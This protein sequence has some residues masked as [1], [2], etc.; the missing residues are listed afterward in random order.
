MRY[1]AAFGPATPADL[2]AW[3]GL[4]GLR[5]VLEGLRPRLRP[6]RD[7]R[8]RELLD[9]PDAPR[10]DPET[11]APPRF[12]PEY[13]NLLLSHADRSRFIVEGERRR[14]GAAPGPVKG[15][16]LHDGTGLGTWWIDRDAA[17]GA[18][19]LNVRR[20][21]RLTARA[22]G[23]VAAEGRRLLRLTDPG[24]GA[25]DVRFTAVD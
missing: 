22:E 20:L 2:V 10:P 8:G 25:R 15:T 4:P 19:T 12:L 5:A 7:E 21:H 18:V 9:L 16:V 11:P 17:S 14:L 1:L 6:F 24:D 23:S 3:S 13:D